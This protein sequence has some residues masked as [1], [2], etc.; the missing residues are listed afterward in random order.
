MPQDPICTS[1]SVVCEVGKRGAAIAS[2][3]YERA[4]N[5]LVTSVHIEDGDRSTDALIGAT[6]PIT[7]LGVQ[8]TFL[9]ETRAIA[10]RRNVD[11]ICQGEKRR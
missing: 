1:R 7:H 4:L 5:L 6:K 9:V 2:R 10:I 8:Q 3:D 11:F